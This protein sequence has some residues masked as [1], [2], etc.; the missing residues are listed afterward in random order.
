MH[1]SGMVYLL[2]AAC[3]VNATEFSKTIAVF[4]QGNEGAFKLHRYNNVFNMT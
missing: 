2:H 4:I 3:V 1:L